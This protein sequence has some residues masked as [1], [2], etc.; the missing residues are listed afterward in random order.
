[1]DKIKNGLFYGTPMEGLVLE[2][3]HP[4]WLGLSYKELIH[5][6][7]DAERKARRAAL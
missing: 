4:E 5:K 7:R 6:I 3:D 2:L 1:M